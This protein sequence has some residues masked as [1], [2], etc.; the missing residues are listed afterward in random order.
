[1]NSR[2]SEYVWEIPADPACR[3]PYQ[4]FSLNLRQLDLDTRDR[5]HLV[6][7]QAALRN[8]LQHQTE[9]STLND[10]VTRKQQP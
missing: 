5:L 9:F 7:L 6:S 3:W 1:M 8:E 10:L 2:G 4:Q